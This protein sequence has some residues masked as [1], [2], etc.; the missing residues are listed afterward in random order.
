MNHADI[1]LG[2][3]LYYYRR[4]SARVAN[5]TSTAQVIHDAFVICYL[6]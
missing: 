4:T 1:K 5:A 6:V 3:T 2:D